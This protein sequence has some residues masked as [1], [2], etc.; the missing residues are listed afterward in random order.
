MSAGT[1]ATVNVSLQPQN[2]FSGTA[3]VTV[4]G[5]P[6]GLTVTPAS[7]FSLAIAGQALNVTAGANAANGNYTLSFQ[8][9]SNSLSASASAA[10]VIE[11]PASF[12]VV[13]TSK[14]LTVQYG[15]SASTTISFN[16]GTGATDYTLQ[17]AASGTPGNITANFSSN[18][19]LPGSQSTLMFTAPA[20]GPT[21]SN[22][23]VTITATR[24]TDG[25]QQSAQI[26]L[27]TLPP[28]TPPSSSRTD[29]V[30]TDDTPSSIAYDSTHNLVFVC[31]AKLSRVDVVS[32][33]S[34][35]I[36]KSI[37]VPGAAGLSLTPD[38]SRLYVGGW[39]QRLSWIDTASLTVVG[40]LIFP[41]VN[42]RVMTAPVLAALSNGKILTYPALVDP[43]TGTATPITGGCSA[44]GLSARSADG[45]KLISSSDTYPSYVCLYD[46]ATN[47][48]S[49][50][51]T[52][53]E[54]AFAVAAN[55]NGTQFAVAAQDQGI[56]LLDSNL[57]TLG[58]APVGGLTTGMVYSTDG[59]LLYVVSDPTGNL[60]LISTVDTQTF[61]LVGAAPAYRG[62]HAGSTGEF[63]EVPMGADATG[64]IFGAADYGLAL[65]D[66]TFYRNFSPTAIYP[67]TFGAQPAEGN[68]NS[69][70]PVSIST[71][72]LS[73]QPSVWFGFRQATNVSLANATLQA[74]AP[75]AAS[76]G[77]VNIRIF[78]PDGAAA[79][80]PQAFSYGP[81]AIT[82]GSL[83]SGPQGG[84]TVDLFGNGFSADAQSAAIKVQI[85]GET[86]P[87]TKAEFSYN[88]TPFALY[89][90]HLQITPPSGS[91]GAHDI[92]INAP[93]GTTTIPKGFHVLNSLEDYPT[94]DTLLD[95]L[96]DQS[97]QQVYLSAGNHV[98]VF[99][100]SSNSY[101]PPITPPSLGGK[102]N[103][104]GMALTPDSS[105]L[106]VAN[107]TDYSVAIVNPDA[108]A[109][110]TAVQIAPPGTYLSP[111][112]DQIATTSLN[113]AF[114]VTGNNAGLEGGGG[115]VYVLDL[116]SLQVSKD[117]DP[118]LFYLQVAGNW[119]SSS[120]DGSGAVIAVPDNSGGPVILYSA[121]T[122][123]WTNQLLGTFLIDGSVSGDG[124]FFSA[125]GTGNPS[126]E[127]SISF[128][129]P[130][131][132]L[133]GTAG[134]PDFLYELSPGGGTSGYLAGSRLNSSG[135][136][137][138][139]PFP[140]GVDIFDVHHGDL[141]ERVYL[142]EQMPAVSGSFGD[143]TSTMVH[144]MAIDETGER[145]FL[146][147]NKGL[148][149]AQLDSAPLSIGSVTPSSGAAGTQVKIR[150]SGFVE[151]TTATANGTAATVY[152]VDSNTLQVTLPSLTAGAVQMT[153]TNPDGQSYTLDD[154]FTVQ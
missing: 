42:G 6:D 38:N 74:T 23:P 68:V 151:A 113:T 78:D 64:M 10:L 11:A 134:L 31:N 112:P 45:T 90:Q 104:V 14:N 123:T 148:T 60:P 63:I 137:L 150:G 152:Y 120:Q 13:P 93:T 103:L 115:S 12:S 66:S 136:L 25:A 85:G 27:S 19:A 147:T 119:I 56:S 52:I 26:V 65:D 77:P 28:A 2:G 99:S 4:S 111:V 81:S 17:L 139:I 133:L 54:F 40:S 7:P 142:T 24:S 128:L 125:L 35:Q 94:S 15:S 48:T 30:R 97:R 20:D 138:Y 55:P 76:P 143:L 73:A 39:T 51:T 67:S 106:L 71:G 44:G 16:P 154:A 34:Q 75:P 32:P 131:A 18:P 135:S 9:S 47:S 110:A 144:N 108:P 118:G 1:S 37:P 61:Q 116:G 95:V 92:V 70:T 114:I 149:I 100:L 126:F 140:Q 8:A 89:L 98:D 69:A 58:T 41:L 29:F 83:A 146:I 33:A 72:N 91:P 22:V 101:L 82:Y 124:N 84:A 86:A 122:N 5:L 107:F 46:A 53:Q 117:N 130:Q 109:S 102:R 141:R 129:D 145:I 105:K 88:D 50:Q 59:R 127:L 57:S 132:N 87:V 43:S 121:A 3:T 62:I 36:V 49:A 21:E 80:M 153:I 96:Y 79:F